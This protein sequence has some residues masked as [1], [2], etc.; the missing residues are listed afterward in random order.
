MSGGRVF[1]KAGIN[2]TIMNVERPTGSFLKLLED[3]PSLE[4]IPHPETFKLFTA[5]VSLVLHPVSPHVPTCHAN[6]RFFDL[7]GLPGGKRVQWFGGGSDLTPT[8]VVDEDAKHFHSNLRKVLDPI[9]TTL[10]PGWKKW[11]DKY[12][13]IAHRG[14]ARGVGGVFFDDE[15]TRP[16]EQYERILRSLGESFGAGYFPIVLKR[17]AQPFDEKELA[18]QQVRRGRYTEFNLVY[19]KGTTYGLRQP[20]ARVDA[21][22][23]SMPPVARFAYRRPVED[24]REVYTQDVLEHPKDW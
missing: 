13:V 20:G 22:L 12:F 3:H 1:S 6:Y 18:Y 21:V 23:M 17:L 5:S 15:H 9:D 4:G 2:V 8:Y 7:Q 10:Y 16:K 14:E 24:Q 19:D 11:C